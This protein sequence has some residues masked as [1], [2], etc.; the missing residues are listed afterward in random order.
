M[1]GASGTYGGKTTFIKGFGG[2]TY[3]KHRL[4]DLRIEER[5]ILKWTFKNW[6]GGTDCIDLAQD[7]DRRQT[8]VNVVMSFRDPKKGEIFLTN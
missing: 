4:E 2:N 8:L 3:G 5:I 1:G 7:T 6:S